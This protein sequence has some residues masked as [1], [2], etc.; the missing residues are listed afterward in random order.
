MKNSMKPHTPSIER[1]LNVWEKVHLLASILSRDDTVYDVIVKEEK[2]ICIRL[3]DY[4]DVIEV[5]VKRT[6]EAKQID[7]DKVT[8]KTRPIDYINNAISE[9]ADLLGMKLKII[10]QD[11]MKFPLMKL[12]DIAFKAGAASA[13]K[14][15]K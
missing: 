2:T 7:P 13:N 10:H 1:D 8:N 5:T 9:T 6:P 12:W 4:K 15:H 14:E 11:M 3:R